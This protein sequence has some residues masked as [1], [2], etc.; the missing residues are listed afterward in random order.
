M[1]HRLLQRR[2]ELLDDE[3]ALDMSEVLQ[4]EVIF[5]LE[6]SIGLFFSVRML[7]AV[8]LFCKCLVSSYRDAW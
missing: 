8:T 7:Y 6:P 3:L 1:H 5:S 2:V 4:Q